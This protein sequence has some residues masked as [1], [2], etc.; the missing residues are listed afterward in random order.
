MTSADSVSSIVGQICAAISAITGRR[1]H[2]E[3]PRSPCRT[4]PSQWEYCDDDRLIEAEAG[5]QL[6]DAFRR[7]LGVGAEHDRD[8]VTGHEADHQEGDDRDAEEDDDEIDERWRAKEREMHVG[9]EP[10]TVR[11]S[12]PRRD[13]CQARAHLPGHIAPA[14]TSERLAMMSKP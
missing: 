2:S 9:P 12:G 3:R 4:P 11:I 13:S 1:V 14:S 7:H 8:R 6:R 10:R 5:A